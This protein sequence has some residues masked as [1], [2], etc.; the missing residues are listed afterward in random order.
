MHVLLQTNHVV[1]FW[2]RS[3]ATVIIRNLRH[4][5]PQTNSC[6]PSPYTLWMIFPLTR[7][8]YSVQHRF[9]HIVNVLWFMNKNDARDVKKYRIF[10]FCS[11]AK[12]SCF[13]IVASLIRHVTKR[14]EQKDSELNL[15][16][17]TAIQ[18]LAAWTP[19]IFLLLCR[20]ENFGCPEELTR[21]TIRWFGLIHANFLMCKSIQ[22]ALDV[23]VWEY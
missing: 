22:F 13:W 19:F 6:Q 21:N 12:M 14:H 15:C 4:G 18:A 2:V 9:E 20:I 7:L 10:Y 23:F 11:V 8:L 16:A 5:T 17:S 1:Q 3:K